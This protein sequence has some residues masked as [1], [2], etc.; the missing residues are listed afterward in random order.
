[1]ITDFVF[2][3][4]FS[5]M[6][7]GENITFNL[8]SFLRRAIRCF[9]PGQ[10]LILLIS[11]YLR[12][13]RSYCPVASGGF[14]LAGLAA[15]S[16]W[17]F[18]LFAPAIQQGIQL[19]SNLTSACSIPEIFPTLLLMRIDR[20]LRGHGCHSTDFVYT[21]A[22]S[23]AVTNFEGKTKDIP[24]SDDRLSHIA[25]HR[26]EITTLV[27]FR[28]RSKSAILGLRFWCVA[29]ELTQHLSSH[30]SRLVPNGYSEG[31]A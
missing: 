2:Q 1:M 4:W 15:K 5:L 18:K 29:N 12:S 27:G 16:H 7:G 3:L 31:F 23:R 28:W 17:R 6:K 9:M 11:K 25:Y 14:S 22:S 24:P 21:A 20:Q 19:I 30:D 10:R 26:A 8:Y 13:G